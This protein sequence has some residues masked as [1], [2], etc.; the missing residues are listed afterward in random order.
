MI[1]LWMTSSTTPNMSSRGTTNMCLSGTRLTNVRLPLIYFALLICPAQ[2]CNWQ[3]SKYPAGNEK[4]NYPAYHNI[5]GGLKARIACT[6]HT[7]LAHAKVAKWYHNEF[8]GK[9]QISFKNSGNYYAPNTT[10]PA[11]ID[12][13]NRQY[14]SV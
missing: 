11:D 3:Y 14:V 7:L 9:G 1:G 6:H 2:Y 8:K 4:G 5:T 12:A 10:S 13:V